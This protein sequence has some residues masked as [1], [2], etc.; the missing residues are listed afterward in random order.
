MLM[1]QLQEEASNDSTEILVKGFGTMTLGQAKRKAITRI[2]QAAAA[3][4]SNPANAQSL[5]YGDGVTK[6][7]LDAIMAATK[8]E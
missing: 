4:E 8:Q 1:K 2:Q 7:L 5:L 3:M 6:A